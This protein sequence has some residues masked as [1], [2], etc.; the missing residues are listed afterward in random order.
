MNDDKEPITP[1]YKSDN[2]SR[3]DSIN[4][5]YSLHDYFRCGTLLRQLCE[6]CLKELLPSSYRSK[7]DSKTK[8]TIEKNLDEQIL[9]LEDFCKHERIDFTP[10]IHLKS[11][12]DLFLNSTAHN[13]IT[14]PFYRREIKACKKALEE[15]SKIN[16]S[17][18]IS[19]NKDLS[20]QI[21]LPDDT[22]TIRLR[23]REENLLLLEYGLTK[24]ISYYSKCEV[25][26]DISK[27][28][29]IQ[30]NEGFESLYEAYRSI[31]GKYNVEVKGDLLD[32]LKD[33]DGVLRDKL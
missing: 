16:R 24:R 4:E 33:R 23:L 25:L 28:G 20:F 5:A 8:L 31:C 7:E 10:F 1:E 2:N 17:K 13:D 30:V 21:D 22:H 9:S 12:K 14:S 11:Y 29:E 15:L 18:G 19:C 32:I 6:R 26:K 27:A 3:I